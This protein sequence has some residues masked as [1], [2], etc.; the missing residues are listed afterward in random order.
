LNPGWHVFEGCAPTSTLEGL[1]G[2]PRHLISIFVE[3]VQAICAS[4]FEAVESHTVVCSCVLY[5]VVKSSVYKGIVMKLL[6]VLLQLVNAAP[7]AK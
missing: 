3:C 4:C 2:V 7:A 5:V 1:A 6:G